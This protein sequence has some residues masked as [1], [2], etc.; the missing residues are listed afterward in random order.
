MS[1]QFHYFHNFVASGSEI[2]KFKDIVVDVF[3]SKNASLFLEP[4]IFMNEN[5][6]SF[7]FVFR[8][9]G[10]IVSIDVR[11]LTKPASYKQFDNVT[12][13]SSGGVDRWKNF[14]I[15]CLD[16]IFEIYDDYIR[17][18]NSKRLAQI[19]V[20]REGLDRASIRAYGHDFMEN[21]SQPFNRY[22]AEL[23]GLRDPRPGFSLGG[24]RKNK[25]RR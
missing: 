14:I 19:H 12:I 3:T 25:K 1:K 11:G 20:M 8:F 6:T 23:A 2:Q 22:I 15:Y 18:R 24:G 16:E 13:S 21:P 17:T 7:N 5:L 9:D 10:Q 4:K